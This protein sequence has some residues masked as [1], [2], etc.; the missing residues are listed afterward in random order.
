M[1]KT[2]ALRTVTL[3]EQA[4]VPFADLRAECTVTL[5]I[6]PIW[7]VCGRAMTFAATVA[8]V[9]PGAGTPTGTVT[10]RA[11]ERPA[12]P[13]TLTD[14]VAT[15]TTQLDAGTH[16]I[17]ADYSGDVRFHAAPRTTLTTQIWRTGFPGPDESVA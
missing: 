14:G 5:D 12:T 16:T 9:P 7:S 2:I 13:A 15:F 1:Q 11:D 10:F 4:A 6:R 3:A 17:T 8:A